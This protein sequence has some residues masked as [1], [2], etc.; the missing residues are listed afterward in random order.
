M[1][2][3]LKVC[4]NHMSGSHL[5]P[6]IPTNSPVSWSPP[7]F[8][9]VPTSSPRSPHNYFTAVPTYN[10][11]YFPL[12][13]TSSPVPTY[14]PLGPHQFPGPHLF[15]N[16]SPP[17]VPTYF[18]SVRFMG[19]GGDRGKWVGIEIKINVPCDGKV[20]RFSFPPPS[21]RLSVFVQDVT[22]GLYNNN[23]DMQAL[24]A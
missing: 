5:I 6:S 23:P 20:S 4:A 21:G 15:S 8:A 22:G 19:T 10:V 9:S 11:M 7:I 1:Y 18:S 24:C 3:R 17:P 12:V 16:Q 14:F 13:P 2:H